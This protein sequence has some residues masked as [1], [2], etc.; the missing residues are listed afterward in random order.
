MRDYRAAL[1]SLRIALARATRD[2]EGVVRGWRQSAQIVSLSAEHAA[3]AGD[4]AGLRDEAAALARIA[5]RAKDLTALS[6]SEA[7][8]RIRE[9]GADVDRIPAPSSPS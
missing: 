2:I 8:Q 4:R 3:R 5:E 7:L 9:V 6:A 1:E